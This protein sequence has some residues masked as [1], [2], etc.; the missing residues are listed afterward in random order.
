MTK[1]LLGAQPVG[2]YNTYTYPGKANLGDQ[3][4]DKFWSF[5]CTLYN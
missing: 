5:L 4:N 2:A 1:S 3:W